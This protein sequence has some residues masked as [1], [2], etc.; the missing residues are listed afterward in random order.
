[1]PYSCLYPVKFSN[2]TG[3]FRETLYAFLNLKQMIATFKHQLFIS[4]IFISLLKILDNHLFISKTC[5]LFD[6]RTTIVTALSSSSEVHNAWLSLNASAEII[7]IKSNI[8][9][10]CIRKK[11]QILCLWIF[12]S[13]CKT[14]FILWQNNQWHPGR[15]KIN[16][17]AFFSRCFGKW[18]WFAL[19]AG[20]A[21]FDIKPF[22]YLRKDK[23]L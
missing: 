3:D 10:Y 16:L 9:K 8:K 22:L 21:R 20:H 12:S 5:G 17:T 14:I 7:L 11:W 13:F 15:M 19:K 6:L 4:K 2:T 1:M 23:V 18:F